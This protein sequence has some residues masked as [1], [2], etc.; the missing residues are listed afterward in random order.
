MSEKLQ[1]FLF[2]SRKPRLLTLLNK[3]KQLSITSVLIINISKKQKKE[4]VK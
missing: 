4:I 2:I 3:L 1:V